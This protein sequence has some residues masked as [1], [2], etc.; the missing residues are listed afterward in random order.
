MYYTEC[1]NC[2]IWKFDYW[3]VLIYLI[4]YELKN[5]IV[6]RLFMMFGLYG[7]S[8]HDNDSKYY[9]TVLILVMK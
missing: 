7:N 8:R 6:E 3:L 1:E 5:T 4:F 9:Q 2:T